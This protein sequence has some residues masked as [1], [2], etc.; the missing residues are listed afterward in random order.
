MGT[1]QK[2][3]TQ[4]T[5][6]SYLGIA[7]GYVN[8][9]LLF[10]NFFNTSEVGLFRILIH[11]AAIYAQFSALGSTSIILKYFPYYK[12]KERK[13]H[14]F[15]FWSILLSF[16]GFISFTFIFFLL[17][18]LIIE[19]Y[20]ETS[21]LLIRYL[22]Y[23]IPLACFTLLYNVLESYLRSLRK[24][25]VPSFIRELLLRLLISVSIGFFAFGLVSFKTF[26][27]IYVGIYSIVILVILIYLIY[28]K[29]LF[30]YPI[31]SFFKI[32]K[33]VPIIRYG[34]YSLLGNITILITSTIDALML[35]AM[36][37]LGEVGIY[38]TAFFITSAIM[39]PARSI[40]KI[41]YPYVAD[42]WKSDK[43]DEIQTLYKKVTLN[44]L[45]FGSIIFIGIWI[46]L[47]NIFALM[48]PEYAGGKWVVLFIG[49]GRMIDLVTGINGIIL[50]TSHKYKYDLYFGIALAILT[51]ITNYLFIPRYGIIGAAFATFLAMS[52]I[53]LS[54]LLF[55]A[56][57]FKIHPFMLNNIWVLLIGGVTLGICS[58]I[59][60]LGNI[61]LDICIRSVVAGLLFFIP[62]FAF[63]LSTDLN[64]IVLKVITRYRI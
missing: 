35:A 2:Q 14:G 32:K 18:P 37:G 29:Q 23:I 13:H 43:L 4:N 51:V 24:T 39:V 61:I 6:I 33:I 40:Y 48:P 38:T 36:I 9:V 60:Y 22:Y 7:L 53:N 30:I 56:V 47:H 26:V 19:Y 12:D 41:T 3:S 10:P 25:V 21:P 59:P 64:K 42:Y 11:I 15:L 5:I 45:V 28:L 17:E 55:V 8:I 54:R 1:I 27:L 16:I 62:V 44:N 52:F 58:M 49:L 20:S 34:I 57:C 50:T 63:K 31:Y 46:N